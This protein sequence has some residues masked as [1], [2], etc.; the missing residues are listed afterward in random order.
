MSQNEITNP[1]K[2]KE[3]QSLETLPT[4]STI[5]SSL[6]PPTPNIKKQSDH[7]QLN[8]GRYT[9][10]P[11]V[12]NTGSIADTSDEKTIVLQDNNLEDKKIEQIVRFEDDDDNKKKTENGT[13]IFSISKQ[14]IEDDTLN[15]DDD[16]DVFILTN[17]L[18]YTGIENV[19]DWLDKTEALFKKFNMGRKARYMSISLLVSKEAKRRYMSKRSMINSYDDFYSFLWSEFD[20]TNTRSEIGSQNISNQ[21]SN[22]Y[23]RNSNY[24]QTAHK[25]DQSIF[26]NNNTL[27]LTGQVPLLNSTT[28][29]R[30]N[31]VANSLAQQPVSR[32]DLTL[33]NMSDMYN[34]PTLNEIRKAIVA[35][36]I[37][38]PKTFKGGKDDAKKWL[39]DIEH[40]FKIAHIPEITKLSLMSYALRGDA[41]DW[42]KL[43]ASAFSSWEVF[44]QALKQAF[45]SSYLDEIAQ[46][47]LEN[48]KQTENQSVRSFYTEILKLCKEAEPEMSEL[49]KVK[50]LVGKSNPSIQFEVRK[51]KPITTTQ[52]LE[53]AREVEELLQLSNLTSVMAIDISQT[54]YTKAPP[55]QISQQHARGRPWNP[56]PSRNAI[57]N[58]SDDSQN[59]NVDNRFKQNPSLYQN[60]TPQNPNTYQRTR[61][62]P[63]QN[64]PSVRP[65]SQAQ[66]RARIYPNNNPAYQP[67]RRSFNPTYQR[68]NNQGQNNQQTDR[69][70]ITRI[71][72]AIDQEIANDEQITQ[73]DT[74][75]E[76]PSS[77]DDGDQQNG[78]DTTVGPNF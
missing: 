30:S 3:S 65:F 73:I 31:G 45:V 21:N 74:S 11:G 37:K 5:Q 4:T 46:K 7:S 20:N 52:Y 33:T 42:F 38:N 14:N 39:E 47:K 16:F 10:K 18:P 43:N 72:N 55:T 6:F 68:D 60:I 63:P 54:T 64:N 8:P 50:H 53:Y 75:R 36:F 1:E 23:F 26:E 58:T 9:L 44:T 32:T 28:V 15:D 69:N 19:N 35:D 48:Y 78:L 29:N 76:N 22:S 25:T 59:N 34:D 27:H 41:L 51:K 77:F 67:Y 57:A 17:F 2:S 49:V 24:S 62:H 13:D 56:L 70:N 12:F 66:S 40:L 71:V 61:Y